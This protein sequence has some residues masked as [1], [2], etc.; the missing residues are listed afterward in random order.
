MAMSSSSTWRHCL[1]RMPRRSRR[2]FRPPSTGRFASDGIHE[3]SSG[4]PLLG[5][6]ELLQYWVADGDLDWAARLSSAAAWINPDHS[7]KPTARQY[8]RIHRHRGGRDG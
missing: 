8:P 2:W 1:T 4:R 7:G 6:H 3:D 5:L